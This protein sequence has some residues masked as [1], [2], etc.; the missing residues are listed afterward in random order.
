MGFKIHWC[1]CLK[2]QFR[3]KG[4]SARLANNGVG[5]DGSHLLHSVYFWIYRTQNQRFVWLPCSNMNA[6]DTDI[7]TCSQ[8]IQC[9]LKTPRIPNEPPKK[10]RGKVG[11]L[12]KALATWA[13]YHRGLGS[14]PIEPLWDRHHEKSC[15]EV[16][17]ASE[18]HKLN[19]RILAHILK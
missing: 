6:H 17:E 3:K 4:H 11:A 19:W 10:S 2:A 16:E 18:V 1:F 5:I 7:Q 13:G 15:C 14:H 8:R 9:L 12:N